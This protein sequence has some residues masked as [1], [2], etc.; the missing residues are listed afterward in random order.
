MIATT[1]VRNSTN[2]LV[3]NTLNIG[4]YA[5]SCI[6]YFLVCSFNFILIVAE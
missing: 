6:M 5:N 3:M 2:P 4:E 1:K